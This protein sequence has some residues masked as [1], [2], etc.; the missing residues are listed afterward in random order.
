MVDA[1]NQQEQMFHEL[2]AAVSFSLMSIWAWNLNLTS[3]THLQWISGAWIV[4]AEWTTRSIVV[5]L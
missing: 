4:N 3:D 5:K 1:E 2:T